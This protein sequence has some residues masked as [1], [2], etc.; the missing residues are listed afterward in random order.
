MSRLSEVESYVCDGRDN[1]PENECGDEG[2]DE[3]TVSVIVRVKRLRVR[4]WLTV[5]VS[6]R[7]GFEGEVENEGEGSSWELKHFNIGI[8][9]S[10]NMHNNRWG[11]ATAELQC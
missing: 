2:E 9:E 7:V 6:V 3:S 4:V 11:R 1:R 8:F 10:M 5:R